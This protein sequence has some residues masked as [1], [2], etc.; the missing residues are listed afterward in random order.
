MVK[1]RIVMEN[2]RYFQNLLSR[3]VVLPLKN[4]AEIED[5]NNALVNI[6]LSVAMVS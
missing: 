3:N 5:L 1:E 6:E 2:A 4:P